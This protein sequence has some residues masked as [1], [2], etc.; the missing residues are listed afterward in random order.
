MLEMDGETR[1]QLLQ[2]LNL[3]AEARLPKKLVGK[4]IEARTLLQPIYP[5][6]KQPILRPTD[7]ALL[8]VMA[9]VQPRENKNAKLDPDPLSHI[10]SARRASFE[11]L[12]PGT[13]VS[14]RRD[15]AE[16]Y[17]RAIF[18]GLAADGRVK[19]KSPEDVEPPWEER[20]GSSQ[21]VIDLTPAVA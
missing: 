9:G 16:D 5:G 8:C 21:V 1:N 15:G 7:L 20:V 11:K 19:V 14:V 6:S 10:P 4:W 12:L 2:M 13:V 18:D 3:P 17:E